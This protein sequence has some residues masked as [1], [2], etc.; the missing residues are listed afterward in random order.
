MYNMVSDPG[1]KVSR[2]PLKLQNLK[3]KENPS[4]R[5][6]LFGFTFHDFEISRRNIIP[7]PSK[8]KYYGL[9]KVSNNIFT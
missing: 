9:A 8:F 4:M 3:Y 1:E 7:S 2:T 6:F 5:T